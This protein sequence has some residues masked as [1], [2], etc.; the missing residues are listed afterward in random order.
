[1][2]DLIYNPREGVS[3]P[4]LHSCLS[5]KFNMI[6]HSEEKICCKVVLAP[7]T[8]DVCPAA[9]N[10]RIDDKPCACNESGDADEPLT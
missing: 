10:L 5:N 4:C 6:H 3:S 9:S 8:F 7:H 1:M 2:N